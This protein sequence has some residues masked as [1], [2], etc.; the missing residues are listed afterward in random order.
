MTIHTPL[1]LIIARHGNTFAAGETPRRVG[2]RTDL[3]LVESGIDQ[4]H[5]MAAWL[6]V[7]HMIPATIYA[8]PLKRTQQ[9]AAI[10]SHDLGLGTIVHTVDFLRELDYGP[11]E[12]QPEEAVIAR[13]GI[14]ALK[15]WEEQAIVPTGWDVDPEQIKRDWVGFAK[16][17]ENTPIDAPVLVITSN[18]IAR[19]AHAIT[20]NFDNSA[21]QHGLKMAT[22]ALSLF[23]KEPDSVSWRC[24]DWNIR[25]QSK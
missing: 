15:Q 5:Q 7:N 6:K 20:D 10:I 25:P 13:I 18:G 11:D 19:F 14:D 9:M 21:Q 12:N 4:A 1:S 2:G 22:G 17:L 24:I 23:R 8:G 3:P 16:D